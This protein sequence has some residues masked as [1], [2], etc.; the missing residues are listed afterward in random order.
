MSHK[1][2]CFWLE[3]TNQVEIELRRYVKG[4]DNRH[5][6]LS[7]MGYHDVTVHTG[8][9]GPASHYPDYVGDTWSHS[10]PRW[11]THCLCGYQFQEKDYWQFYPDSL[12]RRVDTGELMTM[13]AAPAGAMVRADWI[14][15]SGLYVPG[16]DGIVL[17][18][19]LPNGVWWS[20]DGPSVKPDGTLGKGWKRTGTTAQPTAYPSIDCKGVKPYHGWLT[21]GVLTSC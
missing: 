17:M 15:H 6:R 1:V 14:K 11:P 21:D 18:V 2:V 12:Y 10:D 9:R 8:E 3:K 4:E 13:R 7:G 19:K 16:F 5:C 20:P